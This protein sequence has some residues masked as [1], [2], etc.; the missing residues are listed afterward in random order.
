MLAL[1]ITLVIAGVIGW[2]AD[3]LVPGGRLPLGWLGAVLTGIVGAWVGD[4]LFEALHLSFVGP[5]LAGID[6]IPA[7]V[8][9]LVIAFAAQLF[10][11]RR[12][13]V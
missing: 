12:P 6:V 2:A 5:R 9:A 4:L 10:T 8:G 1:L 7:F 13:V 3:L 11:A